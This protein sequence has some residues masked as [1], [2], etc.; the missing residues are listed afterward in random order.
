MRSITN[1]PEALGESLLWKRLHRSRYVPGL[2]LCLIG[3]SVTVIAA[4]SDLDPTFGNSGKVVSSPDG[5]MQWGVATDIPTE[6]AFILISR[7]KR[8]NP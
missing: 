5:S 3:L 2:M 1:A 7:S 6:N 4:P 8:I